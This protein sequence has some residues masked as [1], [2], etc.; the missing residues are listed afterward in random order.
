V[1]EWRKSLLLSADELEGI[2]KNQYRPR[3]PDLSSFTYPIDLYGIPLIDHAELKALGFQVEAGYAFHLYPEKKRIFFRRLDGK[4][5]PYKYFG[6]VRLK[7]L[8]ERFRTIAARLENEEASLAAAARYVKKF[9][10]WAPGSR[11]YHVT[12]KSSV[13]GILKNGIR[14]SRGGSIGPGVYALRKDEISVLTDW[15]DDGVLFE[16]EIDP[17]AKTIDLRSE[18]LRKTMNRYFREGRGDKESFFEMLGVDVV[19]YD[20]ES[21][22]VPA[23]SIRRVGVIRKVRVAP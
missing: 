12:K 15:R 13:D 18:E 6:P 16:L 20:W 9:E 22:D 19:L 8:A 17:E 11:A 5:E 21:Y 14:P 4:E 10:D 7:K 2:S 1:D 3:H 23:M